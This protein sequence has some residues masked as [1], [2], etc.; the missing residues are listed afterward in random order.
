MKIN[1][2]V[3]LANTVA[4]PVAMMVHSIYA[5][6]T[7]TTVVITARFNLLAYEALIQYFIFALFVIILL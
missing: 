7:S 2:R 4:H 5:F 6:I 1:F 3:I